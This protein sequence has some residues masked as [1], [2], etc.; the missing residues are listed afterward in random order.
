MIA[1]VII[2]I[3]VVT[4]LGSGFVTSRIDARNAALSGASD[5]IIS[6]IVGD[7]LRSFKVTEVTGRVRRT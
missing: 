6:S 3:I 5:T 4:A 1:V 2:V 7:S